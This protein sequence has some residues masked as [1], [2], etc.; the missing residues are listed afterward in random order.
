MSSDD[1]DTLTSDPSMTE[2]K[3]IVFSLNPPSAAGPDSM[4][5]KF[6][7]ACWEVI[8]EVFL[9][10][11]LSFFRGNPM[12]RYMTNA[13]L[14]LLPKVEFPKSLTEFR[15]IS[16]SNFINKIFSKVIYSRLGPILPKIISTSQSGFVKGRNISENIILAQKIEHGIK[17]P[18]VWSNVV[19]KLDMAKAYDRVS[20]SFTCIMLRRMG[21]SEMTIDMIRRTMS[22]KRYSVIVNGTRCGFFQS[23]RGLK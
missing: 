10:V 2:L 23:T 1:N 19:I 17:K 3:E 22:K 5:R 4:N 6:Y 20:W 8:K 7:Q 21:F 9:K 13:C 12:P 11:V 16:L 15:S 14:V 18:T